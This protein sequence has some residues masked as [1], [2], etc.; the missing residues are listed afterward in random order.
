MF[1]ICCKLFVWC[2][3]SRLVVALVP[4]FNEERLV[5]SVVVGL[6]MTRGLLLLPDSC[7]SWEAVEVF[8][9][10]VY[11]V[12]HVSFHGLVG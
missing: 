12:Y 5:A 10:A 4:A 1:Q 2:G 6:R 9:V 3:V 11:L 8:I 7:Y